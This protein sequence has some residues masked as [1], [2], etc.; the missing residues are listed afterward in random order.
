[1]S[2]SVRCECGAL[3]RAS[4]DKMGSTA[5]CPKCQFRV[6]LPGDSK[7]AS[8]TAPAL[9][10]WYCVQCAMIN[11]TDRDNCLSCGT[12]RFHTPKRTLEHQRPVIAGVLLAV[13]IVGCIAGVIGAFSGMAEGQLLV[14]ATGLSGFVSGVLMIAVSEIIVYLSRIEE[15]TR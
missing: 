6:L 9:D 5:I 12:W 13:G 3:V 7:E 2:I 4:D 8:Q 14:V 15:N 1:M 10:H 11:L